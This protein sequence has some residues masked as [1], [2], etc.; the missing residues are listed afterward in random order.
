[1]KAAVLHNYREPL[2]VQE[3]ELLPPQKG[4]IKVRFAASGVCH[5]D[6]TRIRGDR[7]SSLPIVL[8]HEAAGIVEEVGPDV[9][10]L[11]PGDH[12][13]LTFLYSCGKCSYCL[14]GR[15]HLC[16]EGLRLLTQGTMVDGTTRLRVDGRVAYHM[17]VS[18]FGEYGV[19]PERCAVK[20][21]SDV[22]LDKAALVGCGVLTGTGAVLNTAKVEPGSS[23]VVIG[24]GGVGLNA[25]QAAALCG[26]GKVIAVDVVPRKLE[27]AR[28]FG[29]THT[30]DASQE[31]PVERVRALTGG[32]GADY[33]F[34]VIGN[35]KT[36]RQA[37]DCV[38]RGGKAVVV[39]V[40]PATAEVS[41]NAM[42]IPFSEKV[43]TGSFYGSMRGGVDVA[44]IIDLYLQKRLRLDQLVTRTYRLEQINEA[45]E[46]LERGELAR[47]VILYD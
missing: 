43:L 47:G 12:V 10:D 18:S 9:T 37:Y 23:V 14:T 3:V 31:D 27:M 7:P 45:F 38:R 4:E 25:I 20:I 16:P 19:L 21:P 8:G 32:D 46:D 30:V 33:A 15:G 24:C 2:R 13:V 22:P 26:A 17:V 41:I 44:R 39:G 42:G 29:A 11:Q 34:E 28:Q 1:M 5:S 6:Y 40:S 36:I 35:P